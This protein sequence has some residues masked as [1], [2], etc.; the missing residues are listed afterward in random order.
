MAISFVEDLHRS[1]LAITFA[2]RPRGTAAGVGY[3]S[4]RHESEYG[5]MLKVR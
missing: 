2:H 4:K 3:S 1:P 5:T